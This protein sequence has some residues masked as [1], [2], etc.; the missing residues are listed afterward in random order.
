MAQPS[1]KLSIQRVQNLTFKPTSQELTLS[2]AIA[3]CDIFINP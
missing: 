1:N 2:L 3:L